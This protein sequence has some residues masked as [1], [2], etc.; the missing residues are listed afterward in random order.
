VEDIAALGLLA[1]FFLFYAV[2]L[3]RLWRIAG[4]ARGMSGSHALLFVLGYLVVILALYSPLEEAAEHHFFMHMI[5]HEL[6]MAVAPPLFVLSQPHAALVWAIP[7]TVLQTRQLR[8]VGLGAWRLLTMPLVATIL[9]GAALWFWHMPRM[10]RA[11]I[12]NEGVHWAQHFSFFVTALFF[13]SSVLG[14]RKNKQ[15]AGIGHLFATSAHT[16]LLGALLVFSTH[17]WL[18]AIRTDSL[19]PLED[20]QLGGLIMWVPGCMIYIIAAIAV[21]GRWIS[22]SGDLAHAR[23]RLDVEGG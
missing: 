10:F 21:A 6:L 16:S 11:A 13:W 22:S 15:G 18:A 2:G 14:Q 17:P 20:Q 12:E 4:V 1:G 23:I 9:H 5:E 8:R 19:T 7:R 3:S